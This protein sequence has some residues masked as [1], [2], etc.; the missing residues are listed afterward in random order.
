M[1]INPKFLYSKGAIK[2][3]E[4]S[5]PKKNVVKNVLIGGVIATIAS[6]G[7]GAWLRNRN[8]YVCVEKN[9]DENGDEND[10]YH[11]EETVE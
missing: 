9:S 10:E 7:V 3:E 5:K 2:M 1:E 11:D 6:I 8:S 4:N